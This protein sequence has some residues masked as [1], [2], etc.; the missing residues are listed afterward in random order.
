MHNTKHVLIRITSRQNNS[1][2][3]NP[4][5]PDVTE[6]F[7]VSISPFYF[8]LTF[9]SLCVNMTIKNITLLKWINLAKCPCY[10]VT[11]L[12][13]L[14]HCQVYF[15]T[16]Q[17]KTLAKCP[18]YRVTCLWMAAPPVPQPHCNTGA[19]RPLKRTP[20]ITKGW[21]IE[22]NLRAKETFRLEIFF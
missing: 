17:M 18:K 6:P 15:M 14:N 13:L 16:I 10:C 21:E 8:Y 22:T 9:G 4:V 19:D 5:C 12:T 11:L 1:K 3:C 7:Q 20:A 2:K